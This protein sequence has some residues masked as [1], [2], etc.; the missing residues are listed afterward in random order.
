VVVDGEVGL[1]DVAE[2]G[3]VGRV[4]DDRDL[5]EAVGLVALSIPCDT[6]RVR[7]AAPVLLPET[8]V[9]QKSLVPMRRGS[10]PEMRATVESDVHRKA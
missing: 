9:S 4:A 2:R 10:I 5:L 7:V 6:V 8:T 3:M 1:E